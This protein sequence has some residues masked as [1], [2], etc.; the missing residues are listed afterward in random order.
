RYQTCV[1]EID[2]ESCSKVLDVDEKR[3]YLMNGWEAKK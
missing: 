1:G 3:K 2:W